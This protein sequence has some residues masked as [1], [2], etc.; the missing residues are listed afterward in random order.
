MKPQDT[1]LGWLLAVSL[2]L[3]SLGFAVFGVRDWKGWVEQTASAGAGRIGLPPITTFEPHVEWKDD[4][5]IHY[6]SEGAFHNMTC[7]VLLLSRWVRTAQGMRTIEMNVIK[8]TIA[9]PGQTLRGRYLME[10][11]AGTRTMPAEGLLPL[12]PGIKREDVISMGADV[13]VFTNFPCEP[14]S[15]EARPWSG[16]AVLFELPLTSDL[17]A[18]K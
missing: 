13:S 2:V 5:T 3:G 11:E 14:I 4:H 9:Q 18:R 8:G 6:R 1:A 16:N 15:P 17:S 10:T 12:P 7:P